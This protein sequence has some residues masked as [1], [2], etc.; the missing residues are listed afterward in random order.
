MSEKHTIHTVGER[1]E[2]LHRKVDDIYD[3]VEGKSAKV[4]G[5]L[6]K[7]HV[8]AVAGLALIVVAVYFGAR[9]F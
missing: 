8:S 4:W 5:F 1:L 9:L 3:R 6:T 7:E 2:A